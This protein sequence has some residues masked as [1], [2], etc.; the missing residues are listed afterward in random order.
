MLTKAR[1]SADPWGTALGPP[2]VLCSYLPSALRRSSPPIL[3]PWWS[4]PANRRGSTAW[5]WSRQTRHGTVGSGTGHTLTSGRSRP[6]SKRGVDQEAAPFPHLCW[7][8]PFLS[9]SSPASASFP[10]PRPS[11]TGMQTG[12]SNQTNKPLCPTAFP[13]QE[14]PPPLGLGTTS[15]S[16]WTVP[17]PSC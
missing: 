9:F 12:L 15:A 17:W 6:R 13:F 14:K 11:N 10:S 7:M 16:R 3:P 8:R 1:L 5:R 4:P 2:H